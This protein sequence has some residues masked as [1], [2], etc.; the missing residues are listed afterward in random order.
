[1]VR[2]DALSDD[3]NGEADVVETVVAPL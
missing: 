2:L 3:D 1:V